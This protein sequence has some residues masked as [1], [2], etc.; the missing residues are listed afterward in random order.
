MGE[1]FN[2]Y[3]Q[4][5]DSFPTSRYSNY[6]ALLYAFPQAHLMAIGAGDKQC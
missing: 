3:G 4:H 1:T 2:R 6:T 5:M